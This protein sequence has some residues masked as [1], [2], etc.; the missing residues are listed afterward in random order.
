MVGTMQNEALASKMVGHNWVFGT[1]E[2]KAKWH[3]VAKDTDYDFAPA[4]DGDM[5]ATAKHLSDTEGKLG[6]KWVIDDLQVDE[7]MNLGSDP[8]CSSAGCTQYKHKKPKLGYEINYPVPN[9]G[10]D[11]DMVATMQNE[12][13]ASKMVGHHWDFGTDESKAKWHNPAKDTD[14]NFA[15]DLDHDMVSTAKHLGDAESKLNHKWVID[16]L[17]TDA[18]MNFY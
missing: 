6:H 11:P 7:S 18:Q 17:Q 1:D 3:N 14:Y 16:D 15:P 2:S 12:A 10:P 9:N 4:L 13:L 8:I 5:I